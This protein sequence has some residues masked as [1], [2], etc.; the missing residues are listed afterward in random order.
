MTV[1]SVERFKH[2]LMLCFFLLISVKAYSN[3]FSREA[4]QLGSDTERKLSECDFAIRGVTH[5]S[6]NSI[7]VFFKYFTFELMVEILE[8]VKVEIPIVKCVD[9]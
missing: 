5:T 6:N 3:S 8:L 2:V 9:I 7:D 4:I 1:D